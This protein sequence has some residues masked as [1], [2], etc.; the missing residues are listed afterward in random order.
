VKK[1]SMIT[2]IT[3]MAL[4]VCL[5]ILSNADKPLTA[6][7]AEARTGASQYP[8]NANGE[9]Y[10]EGPFPAG[11]DQEPD[12]IKASGE[13]GVVGYI[14][15]ADIS[16]TA[17]TTEEALTRQKEIEEAGYQSIPLYESDG[18]TLIGEFRLYPS[19]DAQ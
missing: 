19:G 1:K 3:V 5:F 14:K 9:T 8:V 17:T 11:K 13:N 4:A 15:N 18:A 2:G 12:L 6:K 10:G 7:E 16:E